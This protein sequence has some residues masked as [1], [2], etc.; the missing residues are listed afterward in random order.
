MRIKITGANITG[1]FFS[2][3]GESKS[4]SWAD[5]RSAAAQEDKSLSAAYADI[6]RRAES[7]AESYSPLRVC[8]GRDSSNVWWHAWV[9]TEWGGIG[10][11]RS[12]RGG[13]TIIAAD[14]GGTLAH[15]W[16]ARDDAKCIAARIARISPTH[17]VAVVRA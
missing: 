8:Y 4:A 5:L 3:D 13:L 17:K 14:E 7:Y 12:W 16:M 10:V 11:G 9:E 2:I 1:V 6:L 15:E